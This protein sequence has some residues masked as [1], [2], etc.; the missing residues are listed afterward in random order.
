VTPSLRQ[1]LARNVKAERA[2]RCWSQ[3]DLGRAL[4][5]SQTAVSELE[6]G[7]RRLD[8]DR[9]ANLC[10]ALDVPLLTLLV[11]VPPETIQALG[12]GPDSR[13]APHL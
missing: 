7:H 13:T 9:L 5:M 3:L 6:A 4:G 2:R 12:L 8:I 10:R 1:L 11:G